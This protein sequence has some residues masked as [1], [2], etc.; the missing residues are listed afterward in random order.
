M[1]F[2]DFDVVFTYTR[3]QAIEDGV[4]VD[5]TDTAK[6]LGFRFPVAV[7]STVWHGYII[8]SEDLTCWGQSESGRLWNL[9]FSLYWQII[10]SPP[11]QSIHFKTIFLMPDKRH[12]YIHKTVEL[13]AIASAGDMGE[14]VIT[15]MLPEED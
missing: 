1:D 10:Q 5:I 7:T 14:S 8:P 3:K 2:N 12:D 9:L 6:K 4:L 13:K 11:Q 15:I